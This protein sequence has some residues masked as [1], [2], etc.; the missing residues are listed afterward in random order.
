MSHLLVESELL[1]PLRHKQSLM[2]EQ[3]ALERQDWSC[4]YLA[5]PLSVNITIIAVTAVIIVPK[6]AC[7][8]SSLLLLWFTG[9]ERRADAQEGFVPHHWASPTSAA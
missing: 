5:E 7:H 9:A 2:S 8:R 6:R 4:T 3:I 1:Q